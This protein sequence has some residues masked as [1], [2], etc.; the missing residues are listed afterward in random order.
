MLEVFFSFF[1][2]IS[3]V[4]LKEKGDQDECGDQDEFGPDFIDEGFFLL[5][6]SLL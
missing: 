2:F 4:D 5:K 1:F 3:F 6:F